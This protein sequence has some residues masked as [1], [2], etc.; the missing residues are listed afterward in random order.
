MEVSKLNAVVS[1]PI[2]STAKPGNPTLSFE[3]FE[4]NIYDNTIQNKG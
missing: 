1:F 2:L 3:T 4:T